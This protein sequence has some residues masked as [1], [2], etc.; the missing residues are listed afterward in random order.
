MPTYT[1]LMRGFEYG[2]WSVLPDRGL[3]RDG[4]KERKL[5]PL[6][7]DVF[8][9]LASHHGEVV[10]KDQLVDEVWDG[11]PQ[12]DDVITRCVSALRRGLGDSAKSPKY[13]E[14]VQRRGYRVMLPVM[15]AGG[16]V[17]AEADQPPAARRNPVLIAA[18]LIVVLAIAWI[19]RDGGEPETEPVATITSVAVFPF[20]CLQDA[21]EGGEHL[22]FGFAEEALGSLNEVEDVRIVRKRNSYDGADVVSEDSFVTG[23][24]QIIADQ[25]KIAAQLEDARRGLIIWTDTFDGDKNSI[26]DLQRQVAE[27]LR[28]AIEPDFSDATPDRREPASFA[29]AEAYALGRYLFQKRDHQ[30]TVEAIA[31]F[32]EA[33]RL[34]PS[35]GPAWLGLAY[36]YIIWPDYDLT[37]DRA[38]TYDRLLEII[39]EGIEADP[40]IREAAG[41]V[42]GFV[43]HKRNQWSDALRETG[44]AVN[45]RNPEAEAYNWHSRVLASVGRL[46]EAQQF[47]RRAMETD[48]E[49]PVV[50]SRF[51][52]ASFWVDDLVN[53]GRYFDIANRMELPASI[54]SLAYALYLLRTRQIEPAKAH[55]KA[56][57][58]K[59]RVDSSWVAPVVDGMASIEDRPRA[60][61][62]ADQ[63]AATKALP[64][65]VLLTMWVLLG[66]T[67]KAMAI[68][69]QTEQTGGLFEQELIFIDEFREFRRHPEFM[70]FVEGVGLT[71]YWESAGCAWADDKVVCRE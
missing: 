51:A 34:D 42:Y 11:R 23:S 52:I 56:G 2:P 19:V 68:A 43:Y 49:Y 55:V 70:D 9:V 27:G 62:I 66:E 46:D 33:I 47:A 61:A 10:T 41:A 54:H 45:A 60:I 44:M 48:P 1:E 58:D 71:E 20:D 53:A 38:S 18:G 25:V 59:L 7:M 40:G 14:T 16:A 22:C 24:V 64:G 30:S 63:L 15:P 29:A 4:E 26:F 3:I 31:Q 50:V 37:I 57:L 21:R 35:F 39:A 13:I 28:G 12:T 8:V 17:A 69:R 6:V 67:D 36:T 5:E 32:E 65:N